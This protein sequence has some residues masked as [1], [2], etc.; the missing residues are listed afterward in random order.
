MGIL[1]LVATPIGNLEDITAR[2]LR[3][4]RESPLIAAEDTR[5]T[6]NLLRHFGIA[7]PMISYHAH[8]ARARR[9]QL[10]AALASGDVALVTDAGTPG[11]SDPGNDLVAAA[12][13]AGYQVSPIPGASAL[14]AAVSVSGLVSGAFCMVGFL[15]RQ[16]AD[17]RLAIARAAAAGAPIVVFEAAN[18]VATTLDDLGR[19]LG[20]RS[21]AVMRELTKV[22]EEVRAGSLFELADWARSG[23]PRGEV[24]IVVGEPSVAEDGP[25]DPDDLLA[26]IDRLRRSGLSA[27]ESA[28]EAAKITGKARS[29][30]YALASAWSPAPS[31]FDQLPSGD[32]SGETT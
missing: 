6:G 18:R 12:R 24:V 26:I 28:R 1:Y 20:D 9:E 19:V 13:A 3:V 31:D 32:Q 14:T 5:H 10:I 22:H 23:N 15:P 8:N 7:T 29:E 30:L 27:S 11:I 2:A 4:L 25:V 21:A 16:G 17:R